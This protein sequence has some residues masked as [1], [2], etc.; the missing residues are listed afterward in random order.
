MR[1]ENGQQ[2]VAAK[3]AVGGL[4]GD[5]SSERAPQNFHTHLRR[6][7]ENLRRGVHETIMAKDDNKFFPSKLRAMLDQVEGM[8]LSNGSSW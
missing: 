5:D 6:D 7:R 8:G 3:G 4:L 2:A 1:N